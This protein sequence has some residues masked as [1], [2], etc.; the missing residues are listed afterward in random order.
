MNIRFIHDVFLGGVRI[1]A[2][3]DVAELND[4][5]ERWVRRGAAIKLT[6]EIVDKFDE[7]AT[8]PVYERAVL[9]KRKLGRPPK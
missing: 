7:S 3:D 8:I 6:A 9:A 1:H 4:N 5:T 2:Q